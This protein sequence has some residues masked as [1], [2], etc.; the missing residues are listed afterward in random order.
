MT[1]QVKGLSIENQCSVCSGKWKKNANQ[2]SKKT[3]LKLN[4]CNT[5]SLAWNQA[6]KSKIKCNHDYQYISIC[7]HELQCTKCFKVVLA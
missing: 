6:N 4:L 7:M 3:M 5:H 1:S 2:T